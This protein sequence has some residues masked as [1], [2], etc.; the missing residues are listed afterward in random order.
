MSL[1]WIILKCEISLFFHKIKNAVQRFIYCR[2]GYHRFES[3]KKQLTNRKGE[4]LNVSYIRCKICGSVFFSSKED[5]DI[6]KRI[7]ESKQD[8]F[9]DIVKRMKDMEIPKKSKVKVKEFSGGKK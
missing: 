4:K 1:K 7:E 8:L 2:R 6:Y 3:C 5:K 9:R